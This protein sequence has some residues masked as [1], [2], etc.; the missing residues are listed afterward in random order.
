MT[1]P[2]QAA[3]RAAQATERLHRVLTLFAPNATNVEIKNVNQTPRQIEITNYRAD[4]P[5]GS[6]VYAPHLTIQLG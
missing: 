1:D 6:T 4:L 2:E 5:D 3:A